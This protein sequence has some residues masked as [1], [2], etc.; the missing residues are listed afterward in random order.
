MVVMGE[1]SIRRTR[2]EDQSE[3]FSEREAEKKLASKIIMIRSGFIC[4]SSYQRDK[5]LLL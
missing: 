1:C 5:S 4:G 3:D 2:T